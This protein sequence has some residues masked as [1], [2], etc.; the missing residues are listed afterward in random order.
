M[1]LKEPITD[2]LSLEQTIGADSE[3]SKEFIL[4]R[5]RNIAVNT[6][7]DILVL[8]EQK[9]KVFDSSGKPKT[10]LGGA[11]DGPGEIGPIPSM[12]ISDN[13]Y[14]AITDRNMY[15]NLFAPDFTF[16]SKTR[17]SGNE[18]L[19]D[20]LNEANYSDGDGGGYLKLERYIALDASKSLIEIETRNKD[21]QADYNV[22][23]M[24]IYD[25]GE[26]AKTLVHTLSPRTKGSASGGS[27]GS[28]LRGVF[29]WAILDG[30]K[31]A[32]INTDDDVRDGQ[33]NSTYTM[34]I[35]SFSDREEATII[36]RF[37]PSEI[38]KEIG[39]NQYGKYQPS[40]RGI[41]AD[42]GVIFVILRKRDR[43]KG[44]LIDIFDADKAKYINSAYFKK[45]GS[46][47]GGYLYSR[48]SNEDG[49]P[50]VEKYKI[51]PA[52]YRR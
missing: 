8:D 31:I 7:G 33:D 16:I 25:N 47:F 11:G 48:G 24:L 29:R 26:D 51:N 2:V 45:G 41:Y 15:I 17:I 36:Q 40:I 20:L 49:F 21:I 28:T 32:Y 27:G 23:S 43:E 30:E 3:V 9:I 18:R 39:T 4:A 10:I 6:S 13:D 42:K 38:P 34:H 35:I 52:V 44:S 12:V 1:E 22:Y 5:P 14:I 37:I 50:V 19:S 46:I